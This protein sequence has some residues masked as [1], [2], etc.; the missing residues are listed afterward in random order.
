MC[1]LGAWRDVRALG[2]IKRAVVYPVHPCVVLMSAGL[3]A[4]SVRA[5]PG[6]SAPSAEEVARGAEEGDHVQRL[7]L[8]RG[9]FRPL[10]L[11]IENVGESPI[12]AMCVSIAVEYDD[13]TGTERKTRTA[14][15]VLWAASSSG[16]A[17][18]SAGG[19]AHQPAAPSTPIARSIS[20]SSA[21]DASPLPRRPLALRRTSTSGSDAPLNSPST[22]RSV[23]TKVRLRRAT[24]RKRI[25]SC[26]DGSPL[27]RFASKGSLISSAVSD[28]AGDPS[29]RV[30]GGGD[31]G[32]L[33][34]VCWRRFSTVAVSKTMVTRRRRTTLHGNA[35]LNSSWRQDAKEAASAALELHALELV[36]W[37]L[38][39]YFI[40]RYMSRESC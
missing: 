2:G 11:S 17:D 38:W 37:Q 19:R 21:D 31:G 40:Y 7:A 14:E 36:E 3:G 12:V 1:Y 35:H 20:A 33:S 25:S 8:L 22:P 4:P 13:D 18:A 15:R 28:V 16:G 26:D 39:V 6:G 32:A 24:L 10:Q 5:R 9:E 23:S 27:E 30:R 34:P 29:W